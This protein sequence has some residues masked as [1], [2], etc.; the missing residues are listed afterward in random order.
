[1]TVRFG[2]DTICR[3]CR[4]T[5]NRSGRDCTSCGGSGF[6]HSFDGETY[7]P[8]R[9]ET[10]LNVQ[11]RAVRDLMADGKWRTL[12]RIA[13]ATGHPEASVSA[14]LRDLRKPRFG[15]HTVERRYVGDGLWE[16][17]LAA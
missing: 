17:R 6:A 11:L 2:A 10:R 1:M 3:H 9:D 8:A 12:E 5:G 15:G 14:R 7:E 4:G 16:Y 13:T